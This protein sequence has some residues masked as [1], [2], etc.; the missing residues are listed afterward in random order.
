MIHRIA[1]GGIV[2]KDN[3]ILLVRYKDK[4]G[5]YLVCPGGAIEDRESL[6]DAAVREVVEETGVQ[7]AAGKPIMIENLR[8]NRY[9]MIK[10]WY[11]ADYFSGEARMTKGA[12]D[13]GITEVGWF[14]DEDLINETVYPPIVKNMKIK[15][16]M[17]FN[18]NIIDGGVIFAD[19]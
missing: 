11:S 18:S 10:I 7:I 6:A 12:F 13:E 9:Q 3:K 4:N 1:A 14:S 17:D 19:F 2:I 15:G 16:L 8:G 5:S